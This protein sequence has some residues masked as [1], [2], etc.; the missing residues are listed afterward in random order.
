MD[1]AARRIV[2]DAFRSSPF[3]VDIEGGCGEYTGENSGGA[4]S[5]RRI[6]LCID[7]LSEGGERSELV[8]REI[9]NVGGFYKQCI[10]I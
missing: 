3:A 7:G 8:W 10:P 6:R 1:C 2:I 5:N 4:S 9:V